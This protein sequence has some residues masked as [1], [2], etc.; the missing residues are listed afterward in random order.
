LLIVIAW[1]GT[2]DSMGLVSNV[3]SLAYV[4]ET[5]F[6][7]AG[8]LTMPLLCHLSLQSRNRAHNIQMHTRE[9]GLKREGSESRERVR[10]ERVWRECGKCFDLRYV[11]SNRADPL[12]SRSSEMERNKPFPLRRRFLFLFLFLCFIDLII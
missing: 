3:K 8:S 2:T 10:V 4:T 9:E 7:R 12:Q 11:L 6:L 1:R 5:Q